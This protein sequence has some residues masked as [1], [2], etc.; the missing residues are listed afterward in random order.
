ML[1]TFSVREP[2]LRGDVDRK[3]DVDLAAHDAK[4][5]AA[6]F[7]VGVI[8]ARIGFDGLDNGPGDEVREAELAFALQRALLVDE[9]AV[10]FNNANRNLALRGGDRNR[11][12]GSHV[13]GNAGGGAAN[14]N[15][16]IAGAGDA[17]I[18][19]CGRGGFL[20]NNV[21]YRNGGRHGNCCS[22]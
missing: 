7:G 17:G 4:D 2:S 10:F 9:V 11:Q 6:V 22:R 12:T 14:R 8:Q 21:G 15:E 16:L 5:L 20:G 18:Q 13:L 3:T 1:G 19:L